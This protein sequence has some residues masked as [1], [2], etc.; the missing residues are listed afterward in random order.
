VVPNIEAQ[1]KRQ[2]RALEKLA[3]GDTAAALLII[4]QEDAEEVP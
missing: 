1:A 4:R 3:S 2:R